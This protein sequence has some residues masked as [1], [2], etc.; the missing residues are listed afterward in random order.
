MRVY[1]NKVAF[2][3]HM[4]TLLTL[5]VFLFLILFTG[6]NKYSLHQTLLN[7][8]D[9]LL[10]QGQVDHAYKYIKTITIE[11][12]NSSAVLAHYILLK[13][14]IL[15]KKQLPID[16]DS[17]DYAIFY[18]EEHG[19][20]EQLA[21]AYYYKGVIQFFYRNDSKR[22]ILLLKQAEKTAEGIQNVALQHKI[23]STISYINLLSKNYATAI[24]Y[25]RKA[26]DMAQQGNNKEWMGYSLTYIAN[27]YSGLAKPDSNLEY[28]RQSLKYYEYLTPE[29]QSV[30]LSNI[31]DAYER[32]NDSINANKY[33]E[34]ALKDNPTSYTYAVLAD[35]Y[36]HRGA[37]KQA[38]TY[39]LKAIDTTDVY[40][41]EKVLNSL[42]RLRKSMHDYK[43]AAHI[44]DTLL[45]FKEKQEYIRNENNIYDIQT[46]YERKER[47]KQLNSYRTYTIDILIIFILTVISLI[48]YHKY[49]QAKNYRNLLQKHLLL[50][51]YSTQLNEMKVSQHVTNQELN[52]LKKKVSSL[53]EGEVQILSKGKMLYESILRNQ[54]TVHWSN[55]DFFDFLEYVKFKDM[56][57]VAKLDE[58]Y[59]NLSLKQ[60]LYLVATEYLGKTEEEVG[61]IMGIGSSSVRSVKS[62]IKSKRIKKRENIP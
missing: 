34:R 28:L 27:A 7:K 30:L 60:Y 11:D 4:I 16:N 6:C 13:T 49:K 52:I 25:A 47:E 23:Y 8:I 42:F 54:N 43:G 32:K 1:I 40:T 37:L 22:S 53:K 59:K 33:I 45:A 36:I 57:F 58:T 56:P 9:S 14:E 21:R 2:E 55:Q 38:H 12:R 29:N 50:D 39:L 5:C 18:Y 17:I 62:R 3:R 48:L 20:S 26:G 31:S 61:N 41:Y 44:A 51:E 15:Y 24:R 19:P 10:S 35:I 46:R